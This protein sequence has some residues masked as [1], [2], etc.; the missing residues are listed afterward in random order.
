MVFKQEVLAYSNN[1]LVKLLLFEF[2][3]PRLYFCGSVSYQ[4]HTPG[5][6]APSKQKILYSFRN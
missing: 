5:F 6:T 2:L 3:L 4:K 1:R